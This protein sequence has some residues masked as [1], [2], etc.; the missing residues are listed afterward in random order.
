MSRSGNRYR[1][2]YNQDARRRK[3]GAHEPAKRRLAEELR[4]R[5]LAAEMADATAPDSPSQAKA[6]CDSGDE[7]GAE[8]GESD[9]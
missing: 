2:P 1:D 5:E 8:R 7:S 4:Q 6:E 9:E 3:H